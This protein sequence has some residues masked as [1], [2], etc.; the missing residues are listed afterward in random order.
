MTRAAHAIRHI[1]LKATAVAAAA[2][3]RDYRGA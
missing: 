1:A 2:A 3:Q